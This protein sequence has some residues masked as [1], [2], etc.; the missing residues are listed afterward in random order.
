MGSSF[1]RQ[2][3]AK[4][5]IIIFLSNFRNLNRQLKCKPYPM[6]KREMILNL[7]VFQY[8]MSL[9]LNMGY[10]HIRLSEEGK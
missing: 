5:N 1:F 9:N 6:Q 4:T 3:K 10:Y 2:P 8:A 7:E